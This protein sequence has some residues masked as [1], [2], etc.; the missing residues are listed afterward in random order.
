MHLRL[1]P[2]ALWVIIDVRYASRDLDH[3]HIE[4][5]HSIHIPKHRVKLIPAPKYVTLYLL[6]RH[7]RFSFPP[8]KRLSMNHGLTEESKKA[9]RKYGLRL[10]WDSPSL[11][12][13]V[14]R[15]KTAWL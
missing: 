5:Q 11:S 14:R 2:I 10:A 9:S 13:R 4:C 1:V 7:N 8:T 6:P 15:C 12:M 3:A